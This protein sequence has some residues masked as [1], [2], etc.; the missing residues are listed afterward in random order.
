MIDVATTPQSAQPLDARHARP[1]GVASPHNRLWRCQPP[2]AQPPEESDGNR[3]MCCCVGR[4]PRPPPS[5]SAAAA[6]SPAAAD[7]QLWRPVPCQRLPARSRRTP[8]SSHACLGEIAP[9]IFQDRADHRRPD[10]SSHNSIELCTP[11][12]VQS[13]RPEPRAPAQAYNSRG[14]S[15]SVSGARKCH[16]TRCEQPA[17]CPRPLLR[18]AA[19]LRAPP[20]RGPCRPE[21][22]P[23]ATPDAWLH[24]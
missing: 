15:S 2:P 8:A 1:P 6:S 13:W 7:L 11:P 18:A 22:A 16:P 10:D 23:W 9:N 12:A 5:P 20:A 17:H 19:G 3:R 14:T 21:R 4:S 24:A